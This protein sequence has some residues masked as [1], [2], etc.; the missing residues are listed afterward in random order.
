MKI[1]KKTILLVLVLL[2]FGTVT[3]YAA[4]QDIGMVSSNNSASINWSSLS[5]TGGS[6]S[7]YG[8][9]YSWSRAYT[10]DSWYLPA[11]PSSPPYESDYD[12]SSL[13]L[14]SSTTGVVPD[15]ASSTGSTAADTIFAS[16]VAEVSLPG[17]AYAADSLAQRGLVYKLTSNDTFNFS[18]DYRL[19]SQVL[20]AQTGYAYGYARAWAQLRL[21][22]WVTKKYD[23]IGSPVM[24]EEM[25]NISFS[26]FTSLLP[27]NG[28]LSLS[29]NG[30]AGQYLLLEVG[31][32][33]RSAVQ[34]AVV[35]IPGAVWLLFSG[36]LGL[37]GVRR[38]RK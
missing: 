34:K 13:T 8:N 37:V 10:N 17:D 18:I 20:E 30:S 9:Y 31:V 26:D 7:V 12:N 24:K 28:T 25:N 23:L 22:N 33:A 2:L 4:V 21:Y 14:A 3:V 1:F 19:L 15:F 6:Y 16:A 36:L 27:S 5:I 38:F 35:P 32:D 11:S 29:Y